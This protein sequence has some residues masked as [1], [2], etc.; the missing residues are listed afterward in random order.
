[1]MRKILLVTAGLFFMLANVSAQESWSLEKCIDHAVQ[2]NLMLKL[3]QANV[4]GAELTL[5]Q[6]KAAR[7]PRVNA[8]GNAG[9][10]LGRTIDPTTNA[11]DNQ[12][13]GFNSFSV[14]ASAMV[15]N[16]NSINN[17]I[18]QSQ[19]DLKAAQL[20]GEESVNN[21]A[22]SVANA[23]LS[24]LLAD[25][26]LINARKRLELSQEQLDQTDKLINAGSLPENNRLDF[27][28]RIAQDEQI[29]IDAE[30]LLANSYLNLRQLLELDA[31]QSFDI[32][33]PAVNIPTD[34]PD[35]LSLDEVYATALGLQP[36]VKASDL[37]IKSAQ[38]GESIAKANLLPSL[39]IFGGLSSNYS[40]LAKDF[41]NPDLSGITFEWG[42]PIEVQV[43]GVNAT[44]AQQI[45]VGEIIYPDKKYFTQLEENFGQNIGVSISIPIYNNGINQINI[46]RARINSINQEINSQLVRNTLKTDIQSAVS[47][48]RSGKR[49]YDAAQ[50]ALDAAQAAYDNAQKRFDLGSISTF[51]YSTARNTF[52]QAETSLIRAKYQYIFYLK[53]VDF[54]LGR[55][56]VLD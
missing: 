27:V 33:K 11:F 17:S 56:I 37:R 54:Y 46:Q 10:Q 19:L 3:S 18:K 53:V 38:L 9:L 29:I 52:D 35:L 36:Q 34:N 45:P 55:E 48:A 20:D 26:Q 39:A 13:I 25:D 44:V 23:Y 28:S 31:G 41:S 8:S 43:N 47:N 1:M 14:N 4:A 15:Y 24:I 2:N 5:K 40:S 32:L 22:L 51:E 50:R 6:N 7:L 30:N 49:S 12:T 16:G 21:L 42:A